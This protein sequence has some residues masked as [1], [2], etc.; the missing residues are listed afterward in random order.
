[1]TR[2]VDHKNKL[3]KEVKRVNKNRGKISYPQY[4]FIVVKS[5]DNND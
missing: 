5:R 3:W 1:M 4:R 2:I